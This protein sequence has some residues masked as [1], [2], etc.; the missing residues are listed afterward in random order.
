MARATLSAVAERPVVA[1]CAGKDCAKRCEFGKMRDALERDCDVVDLT[2]LGLCNGPVVVLHAGRKQ[3]VVLSKLRSKQQRK[4]VVA[5]AAGDSQAQ[6]RL[7]KRR[8]TKKKVVGR[9]ARQM[10]QRRPA[11]LRAA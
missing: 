3:R 11:G 5:A 2:C 6:R 4:F 1:M 10:K 8:V 9:V 7:S